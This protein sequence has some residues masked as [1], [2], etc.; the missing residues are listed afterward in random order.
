M[1]GVL[2]SFGDLARTPRWHRKASLF[3]QVLFAPGQ[4]NSVSTKSLPATTHN[5]LHGFLLTGLGLCGG[6]RNGPKFTGF[7]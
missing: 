4:R 5:A 3:D 1:R 2:G 6:G 7:I